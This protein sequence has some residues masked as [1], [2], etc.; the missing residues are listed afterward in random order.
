MK[1]KRKLSITI[2]N[3]LWKEVDQTSRTKKYSKSRLT[4][5]ALKL[6][7]KKE[8]E[9]LMAKGYK[10]MAE[11]GQRFIDITLE[12]QKEVLDE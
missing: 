1:N 3:R 4:E 9:D 11:E 5:E 12:A 8:R 7:F 10:E 2:D 6:W